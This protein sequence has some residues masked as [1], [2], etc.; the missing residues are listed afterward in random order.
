MNTYQ[1]GTNDP[2][3]AQRIHDLMNG[4]SPQA[5][6]TLPLPLPVATVIANAV[7]PAA[8]PAPPA[9]AA[10]P[11]AAPAA[12]PP[13]APAAP[14]HGPAPEGWTIDHVRGALTTMAQN[15]A[16]GPAAVGAL[17]A[18]YTGGAPDL[19]LVDPAQWPNLY[20]EATAG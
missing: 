6:A 13:A 7:P 20:S 17:L 5:Q 18:K 3:L 16:K 10:P 15:P 12:P 9:P 4:G 8:P 14:A 2:A 19:K 1:F 11:P